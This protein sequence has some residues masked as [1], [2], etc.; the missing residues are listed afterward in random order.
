MMTIRNVMDFLMQAAVLPEDTVD[1]LQFGN[2]EDEVKGIAVSFLANQAVIEEA[3]RLGANLLISHEGPFYR[4]RDMGEEQ[5]PDPV[6]QRKV[7]TIKESG[8]AVFRVHDSNHRSNPDG[9]MRGLLRSL[10]WTSFEIACHPHYSILEMPAL[11]LGQILQHIKS[12]LALN[13]LRCMG[14]AGMPCRRIGLLVGYRGSGEAAIPLFHNE[15]LDL[16]I[17]GEGPEWETP[18]Y[19]RDSLQQGLQRGLVVLGHAESETP[20]MKYL[21]HLLQEKYTGMPVHFLPQEP[22][23]T[24]V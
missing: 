3:A 21:A 22:V 1:R 4:H 24:I 11:T 17:Y 15:N 9:V 6:F 16:V 7:Q 5:N 8:I 19:V 13:Y 23:F 14:N 20:G 12:S 10:N 2:T 18:E